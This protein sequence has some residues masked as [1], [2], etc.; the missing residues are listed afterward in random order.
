MIEINDKKILVALSGGVDSAM[1]ASKLQKLGFEV[2]GVHFIMNEKSDAEKTVKKIAKKLNMEIIIKDIS[3][4]FQKEVID[5]FVGEYEK[6]NTPNPCVVCNPKVKFAQLLKLADGLNIEKIAT[7]HYACVE[8]RRN[9]HVLEKAAD[10]TK[11]QSYFLYRLKQNQLERI[12]FP[13]CQSK[14]TE[15][16]KKAAREK[17][18]VQKKESQ[19]VC[20]LLKEK[21]LQDFLRKNIKERKGEIINEEG[22]TI[23][24]HRGSFLYTIG[25]RH[26]L[27]LNGGPHYVIGKDDKKNIIQVSKEMDHPKLWSERI[28]IEGV[29]WTNKEPSSRKKYTAR[30]RYLTK[31]IN[32]QVEKN[33]KKNNWI[34]GLEEPSW[35]VTPGQS[36]V[37]YDGDTVVGGGFIKE[38]S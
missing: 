38:S 24:S 28:L 7:G 15:I 31:E 23:G 3:E 25:Q 26:G 19:D 8:E 9:N 14:K 10:P 30:V 36:L 17:I 27:G 37:V 18:P 21:S 6:G 11:D 32:C 4:L 2:V 29:S 20:F 12:I 34:V 16:K 5:R 13:L 22:E 35:A 33:G 1:S